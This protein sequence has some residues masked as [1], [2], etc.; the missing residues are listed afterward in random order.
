MVCLWKGSGQEQLPHLPIDDADNTDLTNVTTTAA[1]QFPIALLDLPD[2]ADLL[3]HYSGPNP[4]I[5][6]G[7]SGYATEDGWKYGNGINSFKDSKGKLTLYGGKCKLLACDDGAAVYACNANKGRLF[8]NY[9][10][11]PQIGLGNLF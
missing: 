2:L 4:D 11:I 3:A 10:D 6:F 1:G 9:K 5:T 8:L 7:P